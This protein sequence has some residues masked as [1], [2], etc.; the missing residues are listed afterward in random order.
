MCVFIGTVGVSHADFDPRF[1]AA[2]LPQVNDTTVLDYLV[3]QIEADD[4]TLRS[5]RDVVEATLPIL[6]SDVPYGWFRKTI[7]PWLLKHLPD[8]LKNE[9][10]VGI[11]NAFINELNQYN[12][13]LDWI[14]VSV[15]QSGNQ[16]AMLEYFVHGLLSELD[17]NQMFA[18]LL[19]YRSVR[20]FFPINST[21]KPLNEQ[22]Y[23]DTMAFADRLL[24]GDDWAL[25]SKC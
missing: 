9:E 12:Q 10:F 13:S 23:I 2:I 16:I 1:L 3:S 6:E 5:L 15:W 21:D 20:D 17:Y 19:M 4:V 8:L 18:D 22:C 14:P 11:A 25:D 7:F 24:A